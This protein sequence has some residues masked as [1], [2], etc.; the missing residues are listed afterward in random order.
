MPNMDQD[1]VD[2]EIDFM[3]VQ[4]V[5]VIHDAQLKR[6]GGLDGV[7]DM[8]ALESAVMQPQATFGGAYLHEDLFAMAA[9]YAFYIGQAQAFLDGNKR[10][11]IDAALTFLVL[12]GFPVEDQESALYEAMIA[13]AERKMT[14][15]QLA[16]LL[17]ELARV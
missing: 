16:S 15:E 14:K 9:A 12:N 8:R 5:L 6:W 4:E 1:R 3:T 7:R 13:I 10:T 2:S 11:A 17:R